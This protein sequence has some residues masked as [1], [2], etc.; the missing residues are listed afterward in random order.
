MVNGP[1]RK[2]GVIR[3]DRIIV[4]SARDRAIDTQTQIDGETET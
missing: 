3:L 2:G 1:S 4:N